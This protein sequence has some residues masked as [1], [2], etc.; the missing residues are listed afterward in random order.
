VEGG[1]PDETPYKRQLRVLAEAEPSI[2]STPLD[3]FTYLSYYL[4]STLH[5]LLSLLDYTFFTTTT[6]FASLDNMRT[7]FCLTFFL[8]L[9]QAVSLPVNLGNYSFFE[10]HSRYMPDLLV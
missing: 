1:N 2:L 4:I 3:F 10:C 8:A 7:I 5:F 6:C 9:R